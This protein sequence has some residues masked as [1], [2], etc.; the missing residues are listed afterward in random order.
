MC[1]TGRQV[2]TLLPWQVRKKNHDIADWYCTVKE[3]KENRRNVSNQ[4]TPLVVIRQDGCTRPRHQ[5]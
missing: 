4:T 2:N 5:P 3:R 1:K